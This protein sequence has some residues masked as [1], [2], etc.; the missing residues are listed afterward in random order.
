M[1]EVAEFDDELLV[2]NLVDQTEAKSREERRR[3]EQASITRR[4]VT[5]EPLLKQMISESILRSFLEELSHV[6]PGISSVVQ[7]IGL[8]EP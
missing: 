7:L 8:V 3:E 5:D 6:R 2:E 4:R 1:A